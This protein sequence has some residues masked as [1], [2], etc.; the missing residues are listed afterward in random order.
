MAMQDYFKLA[1][2]Q[3]QTPIFQTFFQQR[4]VSIWRFDEWKWGV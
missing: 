2:F 4:K 1:G 3:W